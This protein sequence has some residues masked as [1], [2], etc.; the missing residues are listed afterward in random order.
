MRRASDRAQYRPRAQL[1]RPYP[2]PRFRRDHRGWSARPDQG[3]REGAP[4]LYGNPGRGRR[5]R[6]MSLLKINNVTVRYGRL[7]AL[8]QASL[9]VD[10]GETL[11]ITGPNG[12]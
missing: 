5:S 8:R 4:C 11:F 9:A 10:E 12:A 1:L 2:C 6:P 7:T 3:E